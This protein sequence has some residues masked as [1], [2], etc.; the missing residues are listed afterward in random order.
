MTVSLTGSD[1]NTGL[2][3]LRT[4]R[5][6]V[7]HDY[8]LNLVT[9]LFTSNS[10]HVETYTKPWRIDSSFMWYE[11]HENWIIIAGVTSIWSKDITFQD[12]EST[13]K[14]RAVARPLIWILK[15]PLKQLQWPVSAP[16]QCFNLVS[17]MCVARDID[18]IVKKFVTFSHTR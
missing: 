1:R 13:C 10:I 14:Q 3:A 6:F 16:R 4:V 15:Y 9:S 7:P 12:L 2:L 17:V 5:R 11:E 8:L 18:D